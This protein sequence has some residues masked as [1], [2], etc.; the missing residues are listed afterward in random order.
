[1]RSSEPEAVRHLRSTVAAALLATLFTVSSGGP[2]TG[3]TPPPPPPPPPANAVPVIKSMVASDPR[4]E[5]GVP[6]TLTAA[7]EDAETPPATLTYDWTAPTGTFSGSGST[8]TW[9]AGQDA[10]TPAD[11][12]LTLTVIERYT[13]G[14]TQA[15]H[16]VSTTTTVRLNNSPRELRE[17]SLRFLGDYANSRI[18]PDQCVAEFS[19]SCNG[20]RDERADVDDARHDYEHIGSTLKHTS[21]SIAPNRLTATVHTFCSFTVRVITTQPREEGCL[22]GGCPIGSIGSSTGDCWT[23]NVYENGR[24]WL[25]DSHFTPIPSLTAPATFAPTIFR[26]PRR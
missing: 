12:V 23:T 14:T 7:V 21:L 19:D 3:P 13:S 25:C 6:I 1:M 26:R 10:T 20:K 16:K 11:V 17:M 5:V 4:A 22:K 18:S 24:W 2:G 8:V 15:E 9:V